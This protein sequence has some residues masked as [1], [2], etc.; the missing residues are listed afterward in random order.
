[1]RPV[2]VAPSSATGSSAPNDTHENHNMTASRASTAV[3]ETQRRRKSHRSRGAREGQQQATAVPGRHF[4]GALTSGDAGAEGQA[5]TRLPSL[6]VE[7][8]E[9]VPG[10]AYQPLP[11]TQKQ[12]ARRRRPSRST[13]N[14]IATRI[15][16]D[17]DNANYECPICTSEVR[18]K[19]KIWSCH[20]CWTVFHLHCI[21]QWAS[22]A[23]NAPEQQG[24]PQQ[25]Q[26][27]R[28]P[29]CNLPQDAKPGRYTCWC[30]KDQEPSS[31]V[32][33][34]P[35]SC[36]Q[37]CGQER[38]LPRKCPHRCDL[39][40]HAGPC[41]P[42]TQMGPK[43]S[44]FCGKDVSQKKCAETTYDAGWSCGQ[45]CGELMPCGEH[46]CE[47][48][49]HEGLCGACEVRVPARCYCGKE[50]KPILCADRDDDKPST[51]RHLT[52]QGESITETWTGM[53]QCPGRCER[54]FDCGVHTCQKPCHDQE[55]SLAH[56]PRSP[57][58]V[59]HCPCGKTSLESILGDTPRNSCEDGV[60]NC[61]E[62][63]AKELS[64]GHHCQQ[65]CHTGD[66]KPCF[67]E[68][69]IYCRCGRTAVPSMCHQGTVEPPQCYR[70][71][72]ATLNCGRHECGERCCS[73]ER[74]AVERQQNKRKMRPLGSARP[75]A[76]GFEA[77]HICTRV[78]GRG[79][80]CG[81]HECQELCHRGACGSCR[82]AIFDEVAC[83][84]GR[85]VLQPPLPCGTQSPPCRYNC[86]RP[87]DCGHPQ[88]AHN[89][90]R[91]EE[92]CPKCPFLVEKSCVC[93]KKTLKNQQ[94][95]F[96]EVHCGEIC[97]RR[98]KCGSHFCRKT[99]HAAGGCEDGSGRCTQPCGK[100][101]AM[102]SHPDEEMCHAP[103]PC[104]EDK[105]CPQ[106]AIITCPCQHR[107]QEIRCHATKEHEGNTTKTL[108]CDEECA[109]LERNHRLR[110]AL[111]IPDDHTNEH[112]PYSQETLDLCA[113][114]SKW[115]QE[116]EREFRVFAADAEEKR[117]R[118]KA[119]PSH[120]RALLHHLAEDFGF[121]SE[122][123]D[124]EPHRHVVIFRTPRFEKPPAKTLR[125]CLKIRRTQAQMQ[126][127][128]RAKA[129][130]AR[131]ST[132][133]EPYNGYL[134]SQARFALTVDEVEAELRAALGPSP[135]VTFNVQFLSTGDVALKALSPSEE[136]ARDLALKETRLAIR[137][138][139]T[140][141]GLGSV[142]L[143]RFD[144]SLNVLLRESDSVSEGGWSQ[145]AAKAAATRPV[146][147]AS[148]DAD[149]SNGFAVLSNLQARKRA[150]A[151]EEK[152]RVAS[153]V[154]EDWEAAETAE[155][156]KETRS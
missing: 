60:P 145:V 154:V 80:K 156:A 37:T 150:A 1:M 74:K 4:G 126:A 123:M 131:S 61:E 143:A 23:N 62:M 8:T 41:P 84:C 67:Q 103:Y 89:C 116:M 81:N 25:P 17:I 66:C 28:C 130:A 26:Q 113:E 20:T 139:F 48:E 111:D 72:K 92:K 98:L 114:Q 19:S 64:C 58:V 3:A 155:E 55:A 109:R 142:Q 76:E 120:Q 125:E 40:C 78:C 22:N 5:P 59:T 141:N 106:K 15:H 149:R 96:Q 101:K 16:E 90:H 85:T 54:P 38:A 118:F 115:A 13:A 52:E 151:E 104:K 7:A 33:L 39:M 93:G 35:H 132:V 6:S 2:N 79:L 138:G 32:G 21:K 36:G 134:I 99:C 86:E 82:E 95:W 147:S 9:F 68:V 11:P 117:L 146:V 47:R 49:C 119:M 124:P 43:Q 91:E 110:V 121:D 94:C 53:F 105:P 14:D 87:K 83:N 100:A 140:S 153:P 108:A 75:V 69:T 88:V 65:I 148:R 70:T 127:E 137:R 97:G 57:D 128:E 18:R 50:D 152:K 29:G 24:Q 112:V 77:E 73:G 45:I 30:G 135:R 133:R 42:C 10:N 144:E 12:P 44:C 63:C 46:T 136:K 34:P 107:R 71:C 56:C 122:S 102:C 129:K 27:W 51:R 31:T